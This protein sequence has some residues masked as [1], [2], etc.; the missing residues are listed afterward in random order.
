[1]SRTFKLKRKSL[2]SS[3]PEL[4]DAWVIQYCY[5][6]LFE[7]SL[8]SETGHVTQ[9]IAN[10]HYMNQQGNAEIQSF[11]CSDSPVAGRSLCLAHF[12]A[13]NI[14]ADCNQSQSCSYLIL[15][16]C[17]PIMKRRLIASFSMLN[18][19]PAC[20]WDF[21]LMEMAFAAGDHLPV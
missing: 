19:V 18:S 9:R 15:P 7:S 13:G 5:L 16:C 4:C 2:K 10:S 11:A 8:N 20:R 3:A 1:M 17:S 12:H 14:L 6:N 21:S